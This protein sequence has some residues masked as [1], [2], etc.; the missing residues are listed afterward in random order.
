MT[1][2]LSR[3]SVRGD[4]SERLDAAVRSV[5]G[6]GL[7]RIFKILR[8][9]QSDNKGVEWQAFQCAG[10]NVLAS[11]LIPKYLDVLA[12]VHLCETSG[13]RET[14]IIGGTLAQRQ[15]IANL[16]GRHPGMLGALRGL[17]ASLISRPFTMAKCLYQA[18]S[19]WCAFQM[20]PNR[21]ARG[22]SDIALFTYIDGASR[23]DVEPYFGQLR[24]HLLEKA[25]HLRIV[26][27]A[28]VYSPYRARLREIPADHASIYLPLWGFLK[29]G[30]Y[31]WAL[32]KTM[33]LRSRSF[34]DRLRRSDVFFEKIAT[35]FEENIR[36]DLARGYLHHLLAYKAAQ[37]VAEACIAKKIIYPF[38]NKA[39]EKC[40]LLGLKNST[41]IS[42]VG[43]Q[44][45][46]ISDRHFNFLIDDQELENTPWPEKVVTL[47]PL[48]KSWL[49]TR[50]GFPA[51]FLVQGC[52]L[53]HN[54][55]DRLVKDRFGA[56]S[57]KLLL[58]TS[59]SN[60]ELVAGI[61]FIQQLS[62]KS[63]RL[64]FAVR[65]HHNFPLSS[66]PLHQ[67]QWLSRNTT[68]FSGTRLSDNL[69]WADIVLYVS[70]TVALE[71]LQ[72]GIPVIRLN[73]DILDSDP[74]IGDA[75]YC[76]QVNTPAECL[77]AIAS[78]AALPTEQKEAL[79]NDARDYI[80]R[81]MTPPTPEA[82]V[83]FM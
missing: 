60:H 41:A 54:N 76:W 46:S 37:R 17:L 7:P 31:I 36:G 70:S 57:A 52:S 81:Y 2:D 34:L 6:E 71:S 44:H 11:D 24:D 39:I 29:A 59:S 45:S 62:K 75:P 56:K 49:A 8:Q 80:H 63:S 14:K 22:E 27:L 10:K 33:F 42:V 19:M 38:E 79:I 13:D 72:C 40:L 58:V 48:T 1:I 83:A 5:S 26:Y 18:A 4:G 68:D 65:P 21:W 23:K 73:V 16:S 67:R 69:A 74:V 50:G 32:K 82:L 43:Y 30:D 66:T 51:E 55:R 35:L 64:Q 12:C 3:T 15:A 61:A 28:C 78:I 9:L 47:G 77:D 25:P 53:R 20:R